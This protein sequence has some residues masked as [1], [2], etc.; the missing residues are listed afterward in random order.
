MRNKKLSAVLFFVA[1]SLIVFVTSPLVFSAVNGIHQPILIVGNNSFTLANGVSRGSGTNSDPY[2]IENL[3]V[4]A[5]DS[6]GIQVKDTTAYFIVRN[7][8]VENGINFYGIYLDNVT[9]GKVKNNICRG[10]YEGIAVCS[11][12]DTIISSNICEDNYFGIAIENSQSNLFENNTCRNDTSCGI[13]MH[14]SKY[15]NLTNNN[16]GGSELSLDLGETGNQTVDEDFLKTFGYCINGI[17]LYSSPYNN[18][19]NNICQNG[20]HT[21]IKLSN[22]SY[23]NLTGNICTINNVGIY[24]ES[25]GVNNIC[26]NICA[27]N[28]YGMGLTSSSSYNILSNNT[29]ESNLFY[30]IHLTLQSANNNLS[31]NTCIGNKKGICLQSSLNNTLVGNICKS[32]LY[33]G[34]QLYNSSSN[35]L[36]SNVC[37]DNSCDIFQRAS[38]NNNLTDNIETI[39]DETA[40]PPPVPVALSFTCLFF[41]PTAV[42]MVLVFKMLGRNRR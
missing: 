33:F 29:C 36:E 31:S 21:G 14:L 22:S 39:R 42:L 13:T 15:N 19:T 34:I 26:G 23:G 30:G 25:S 16:L 17:A 35:S 38:P 11:S 7:C 20:Y 5:S 32:N 1:A 18:L 12:S 4:D 9:N 6:N 24:L 8:L 37:L 28:S 2:V 40:E 3:V 10:N 27:G 41:V